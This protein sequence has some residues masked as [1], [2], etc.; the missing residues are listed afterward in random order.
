MTRVEPQLELRRAVPCASA[1]V[2]L[3]FFALQPFLP[4]PHTLVPSLNHSMEI[5]RGVILEHRFRHHCF[6]VSQLLYTLIRVKARFDRL[7]GFNRL[8]N[9]VD[10]F[11]ISVALFL[12]FS[13]FFISVFHIETE[14]QLSQLNVSVL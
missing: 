2:R 9:F 12:D 10:R 11:G 6:A 13:E 5:M 14:S 1:F 4:Q 7:A 3:L 8:L